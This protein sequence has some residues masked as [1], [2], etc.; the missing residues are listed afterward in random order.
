MV[1]TTPEEIK[2]MEIGITKDILNSRQGNDSKITP[3]LAIKNYLNSL[4]ATDNKA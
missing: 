2:G 4:K 3:Q 1:K